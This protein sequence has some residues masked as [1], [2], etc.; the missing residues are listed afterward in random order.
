[1]LSAG[2]GAYREELK[3]NRKRSYR[4]AGIQ[5]IIIAAEDLAGVEFGLAPLI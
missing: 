4:V 3:K 2:E 1:M 5:V